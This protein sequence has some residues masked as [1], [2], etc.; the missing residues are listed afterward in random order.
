MEELLLL[1]AFLRTGASD[2]SDSERGALALAHGWDT[3]VISPRASLRFRVE[4]QRFLMAL[5]VLQHS[6]EF[7]ANSDNKPT[8]KPFCGCITF[9]RRYLLGHS[10]FRD[11]DI[12]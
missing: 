5:S 3:P 10:L 6:K 1:R 8:G 12:C 4:F 7:R 9:G 2:S 11:F